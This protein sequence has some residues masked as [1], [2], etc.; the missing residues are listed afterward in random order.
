MAY[1]IK[2]LH[3]IVTHV[4]IAM[5]IFSFI[6]DLLARILKKQDW[7]TAGFLCLIVGTL[8]AI[9]AVLTGPDDN[10]PLVHTHEL[11]G[12]TTMIVFILISLIRL[13][14]HFRKKVEI[15]RMPVYLVATLIGAVLVGYTGHL[16]GQ[17]VHKDPT[18]NFRGGPPGGNF[19][20]NPQGGNRQGNPQGGNRQG[21]PQGG[22]QQGNNPQSNNP[23]ATPAG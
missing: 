12:K 20:G 8:G 1:I 23:Q 6:F 3:F 17:M 22:N 13:Y 16:G 19:Q 14:F 15:G 10:S 5:L 4:P 9:A 21:N 7:H 11:F 2:N 18:G